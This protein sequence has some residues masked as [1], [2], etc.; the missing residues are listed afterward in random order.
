MRIFSL[1]YFRQIV[2]SDEVHFLF[3]KKKNQF[4]MKNQLGPFIFNN[5]EARPKVDRLLQ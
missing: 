4:K 5:R 2:N 1:E 3:A